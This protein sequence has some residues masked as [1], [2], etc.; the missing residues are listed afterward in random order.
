MDPSQVD[1]ILVRPEHPGNLAAACRAMKNMG[2][3]RLAVVGPPAGLVDPAARALAYGAWDVLDGRREVATLAE[4]VAPCTLVVGT[5]GRPHAEA[6]TPRRLAEEGG[7]RAAAGRVG[8]VF[9]PERS[10]LTSQ[11]LGLCQVRVHIPAHPAQPSLNLAQAVLI[12]CYEVSLSA[13]GLQP[14]P[15]APVASAGELE[16][17]VQ[18]LREGLLG[19]GFLNADN[20]EP[21]LSEIR[22]LLARRLPTPREVSLLRGLARQVRWAAKRCV[23]PGPPA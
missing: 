7:R 11:E 1:V 13:R 5:S 23:D 10:G 16:A 19:I 12:L 17:A 15:E 3:S 6:W 22:G 18:E 4:A 21:I 14:A 8:L 2:V 9:G 20:P